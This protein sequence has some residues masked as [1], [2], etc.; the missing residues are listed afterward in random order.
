[1][2]SEMCIRD[3]RG[4]ASTSRMRKFCREFMSF[5]RNWTFRSP[6]F[7]RLSRCWE[8]IRKPIESPIEEI[9]RT[10]EEKG[11]ILL[12]VQEKGAI[13]LFGQQ[14]RF[15]GD[16]PLPERTFR[17][18]LYSPAKTVPRRA[19]DVSPRV[20]ARSQNRK[21]RN[22]RTTKSSRGRECTGAREKSKSQNQKSSH[23]QVEPWT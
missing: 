2:G 21:I 23:N 18:M 14:N 10:R 19:V 22:H 1:M 16:D 6:S 17:H 7:V 9:H 11:A 5:W 4:T 13:L 20:R 8:M 12:F 3:R 15:Q